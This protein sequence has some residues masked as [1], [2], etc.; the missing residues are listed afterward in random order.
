MNSKN[1]KTSGSHRLK[2]KL[3]RNDKYVPLANLIIYN[4]WKN[5]TISYKNNTFK[6]S[7][8]TSNKKFEL[9]H[10]SY[11]ISDIQEYFKYIIKN[12]EQYMIIQ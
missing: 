10:G 6:I 5:I 8:P 7:A 1:S 3:K 11:S 9:P 4:T 12:M 2:I